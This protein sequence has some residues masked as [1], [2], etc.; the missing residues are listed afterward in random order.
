M[1]APV[2]HITTVPSWKEIAD[3]YSDI[4]N[5]KSEED[6]EITALYKQ[7]FP[8]EKKSMAQFQKAKIIYEYIESNIK[9]SS[10][11]FRQS[12][13]VPQKASSTL[14]T[15]L[16]DCKDLS[17][18]FVTLTHMAG[19]SS[20]M[21]LVDTRD[22]GQKDIMLPGMQFNHCIAK[23]NLDN[24]NY[25]IELTDNYLPFTSLPNNLNGAIALEIPSKTVNEKA[26]LIKLKGTTRVRDIVK[27]L[28]DITPVDEDLDI[29]VKSIKCGAL[30][31]G[32][33]EAYQHLDKDKQM[34]EME[35]TVAGSYKNNVRLTDVSFKD[36]DKLN[37]SVVY[38][39]NYMVKNEVSEIGSLN[40]FK[41]SYPD[42]V[43]SLNSFSA[44]TRDYP[45]EYWSYEDADNYETIVNIKAPAGKKFVELPTDIT[46]VFKDM[47]FSLTYSLKSP[48][49]LVV[50]RK[51][52]NDRQ[53]Q[54]LPAD[55]PA[56]KSFF[57][58]IVKAE[59]K[60]IAYK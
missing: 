24:K 18:L 3:W 12:S 22:N 51:F 2:L 17:N 45:V 36:L 5:N 58:K 14:T 39:Y 26:E 56:F 52:S 29:S 30:S 11:S 8:D 20:Q 49:K 1:Q 60:F 50:T 44:D 27:K 37:D 59:Q 21:V 33:R 19:I 40:T 43:A 38:T 28:I 10:V 9:Y 53:Q 35:K 34:K 16:G 47:K 25:Y 31:S 13:Y 32:T 48:D 6:F 57:E 7:L 41:I 55:Y 46:L 54:V 23:A 4:V 42:I 15:R